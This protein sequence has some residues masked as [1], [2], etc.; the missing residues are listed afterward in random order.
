VP[1]LLGI[2]KGNSPLPIDVKQ[3]SDSLRALGLEQIIGCIEKNR[4]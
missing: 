4:E 3:V 2:Q 1:F